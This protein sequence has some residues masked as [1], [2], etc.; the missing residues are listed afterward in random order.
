MKVVL[1]TKVLLPALMGA[2]FCHELLTFLLENDAVTIVSSEHILS[3]F[4]EHATRFR[5]PTRDVNEAVR[6]LRRATEIVAPAA[7]D[8]P[9]LRDRDDVPVLGTAVAAGASALVT[10]DKELLSLG[11]IQS[12][13]I[14]SPRDFY[15]RLR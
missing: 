5:A 12:I 8:A 10:G 9:Q 4:R 11:H 1:D 13:P 6:L 2:G 14:L 3:E 7:V 15:E